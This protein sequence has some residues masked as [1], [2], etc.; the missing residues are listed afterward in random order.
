MSESVVKPVFHK[1][2]QRDDSTPHNLV[3]RKRKYLKKR[4]C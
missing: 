3:Y 4:A 2:N 1:T